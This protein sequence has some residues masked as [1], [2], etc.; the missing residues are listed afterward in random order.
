VA[1][2]A[3]A[4]ERMV[5]PALAAAQ[6]ALAAAPVAAVTRVLVAAPAGA[7]RPVVTRAVAAA[8]EV[9]AVVWTDHSR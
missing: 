1:A 3:G 5:T 8:R 6:E 4:A 9:V 7:A 2:P